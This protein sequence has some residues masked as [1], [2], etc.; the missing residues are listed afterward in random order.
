MLANHLKQR[1]IS[2]LENFF[3]PLS[4]TRRCRRGADR[5]HTMRGQRRAACSLPAIGIAVL[6]RAAAPIASVPGQ[7]RPGNIRRSRGP[8]RSRRNRQHHAERPAV[9]TSGR[10]NDAFELA[11]TSRV[12]G[13]PSASSN[14]RRA[15][16]NLAG[17][18]RLL[19][20]GLFGLFGCTPWSAG[21]CLFFARSRLAA[22]LDA[23]S[24]RFH[25][26]DNVGGL[27]PFRSLDRPALKLECT[28]RRR[29]R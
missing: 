18:S 5:R 28:S 2:R 10:C 17:S 14:P 13:S 26:V 6:R 1:W 11:Q 25:Q 27:T 15:F 16:E 20:L 19:P 12:A 24:Q 21:T 7:F 23:P 22:R 8:V 4:T 3:G 9:R 29:K